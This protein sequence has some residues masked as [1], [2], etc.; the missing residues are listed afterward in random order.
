MQTAVVR[1]V[2]Q[3]AAHGE[4]SVDLIG[5]VHVGEKSYYEALNKLFEDY[6]VVLY[7]LVA[8]PGT[9]IP[10]GGKT[11][12]HPVAMLQNGMKDVLGL[13]HQLEYIDYT[14]GKPG[15]RRHVAR[16]FLE[17]DDRPRRKLGRR[18]SFA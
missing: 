3:D 8:P 5:A 15:A 12:N 2:P 1:Y 4:L 17:V 13:E 7:E 9:R 10:K 18:C 14:Q 16:R 6:D 11:S